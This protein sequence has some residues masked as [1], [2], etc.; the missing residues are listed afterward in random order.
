MDD[1]EGS[2]RPYATTSDSNFQAATN[3]SAQA[4]A[5][6]QAFLALWNPIAAQFNLT[7]YTPGQI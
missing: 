3:A 6:K 1:V 2:S 4:D 5:A 7:Q